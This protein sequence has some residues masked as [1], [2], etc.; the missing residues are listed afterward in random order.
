MSECKFPKIWKNET[1]DKCV[2]NCPEGT[3]PR[4]D[5]YGNFK[6]AQDCAL[7]IARNLATGFL[8]IGAKL[9]IGKSIS[10]N[11]MWI[12]DTENRLSGTYYGPLQS[13]IPQGIG[14]MTFDNGNIYYGNWKLGKM[15]GNGVILDNNGNLLYDG[16]FTNDM[17]DGIGKQLY[18]NGDKYEGNYI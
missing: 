16:E 18:S 4:Y 14:L 15:D 13:G 10:D 2:S 6:C 5:I 9:A 8:N 3:C 11:G 7:T 12:D 17:M 1:N